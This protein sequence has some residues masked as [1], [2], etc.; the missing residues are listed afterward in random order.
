MKPAE[1]LPADMICTNCGWNLGKGHIMSK[2]TTSACGEYL[3]IACQTCGKV[4]GAITGKDGVQ[5]RIKLTDFGR[6]FLE[7]MDMRG[8][9]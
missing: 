3:G 5:L 1:V 2:H 8:T 4:Y 9:M 6:D 7:I